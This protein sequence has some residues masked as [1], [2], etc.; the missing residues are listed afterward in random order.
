MLKRFYRLPEQE[1]R[2]RE[3][4]EKVS[5]AGFL[6]RVLGLKRRWRDELESTRKTHASARSRF[7]ERIQALEKRR[8]EELRIL[9]DQHMRA[10]ELL[11]K[12]VR[13]RAPLKNRYFPI[14]EH[15]EG[16]IREPLRIEI[17]AQD[18]MP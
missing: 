1:K 4:E 12:I 7:E 10:R 3:L 11:Q 5:K 14:L 2:I 16:I 18:R 8:N 6:K 17:T 13:I 15:E 9:A